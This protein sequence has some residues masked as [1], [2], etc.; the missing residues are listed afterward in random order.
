MLLHASGQD[1]EAGQRLQ[2]VMGK[3]SDVQIQYL[4]R[5]GVREILTTK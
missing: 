1:T 3:A 4:A 2:E 5:L